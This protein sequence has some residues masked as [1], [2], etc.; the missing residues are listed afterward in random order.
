MLSLDLPPALQKAVHRAV[1]QDYADLSLALLSAGA[2]G[3]SWRSL[4]TDWRY[5]TAAAQLAGSRDKAL[6][7]VDVL[8]WVDRALR[9]GSPSSLRV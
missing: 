1:A 4:W 5:R 8:R 7:L 6:W 3:E 2:W 9:P